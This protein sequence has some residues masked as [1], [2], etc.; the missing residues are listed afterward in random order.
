MYYFLPTGSV[1]DDLG[2]NVKSAR[3][4][5]MTTVRVRGTEKALRELEALLGVRL[6]ERVML[7]E[8][9]DGGND[10]SGYSG[11]VENS[12]LDTRYNCISKL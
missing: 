10:K 1:L 2:G 11:L 4:V 8:A 5:G 9:V 3:E 7:E 6:A 12:E